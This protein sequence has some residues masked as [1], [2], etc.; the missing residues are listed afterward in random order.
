MSFNL[1]LSSQTEICIWAPYISTKQGT[2][3]VISFKA[4]FVQELKFQTGSYFQKI[5]KYDLYTLFR[6]DSHE[7]YVPS[8]GR[9]GKKKKT[10]PVQ[11]HIPV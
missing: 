2:A 3:H 8:L 9:R 6:K 1:T 7:G 10:Y 11:R 5:Y 4:P